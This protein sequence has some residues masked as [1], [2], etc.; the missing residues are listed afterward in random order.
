M[1]NGKIVGVFDAK[2]FS[3]GQETSPA[4]VKML[5]Y[6]SNFNSDFGVLFFPFVPEFWDEMNKK[7][8]RKAL[9]SH[10]SKR[11]SKKSEDELLVLDVVG[12]KRICF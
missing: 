8:K 2:N 4:R 6:M 10:Y 3:Q 11:F 5:S 12:L 9:L 7:Q 1:V